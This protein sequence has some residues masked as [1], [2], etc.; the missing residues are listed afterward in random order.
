MKT[1]LLLLLVLLAGCETKPAPA[2][3]PAPTPAPVVKAPE[4]YLLIAAG[5]QGVHIQDFNAM[6]RCA[7]AAVYIKVGTNDKYIAQCVAK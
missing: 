5:P 2:P 4:T 1:V 7:E 6:D 3:V